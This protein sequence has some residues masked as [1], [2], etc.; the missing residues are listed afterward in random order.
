M[1]GICNRNERVVSYKK[2]PQPGTI[3][4]RVELIPRRPPTNE[5]FQLKARL[6]R[7]KQQLRDAQINI[8]E[9]GEAVVLIEDD[10]L[11]RK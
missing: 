8:L 7:L 1:K 4:L 9:F 3:D 6:R 5:K 10:Y 2:G 11:F